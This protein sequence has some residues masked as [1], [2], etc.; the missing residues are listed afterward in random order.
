MDALFDSYEAAESAYRSYARRLGFG[1]R[2]D[3]AIRKD[4]AV[5]KRTFVCHREGKPPCRKE[6]QNQELIQ[7]QPRSRDSSRCGCLAMM[8]ISL[9]RDSLSATFRHW[10]VIAFR[11]VLRNNTNAYLNH[12]RSEH[13]H[14]L[15][16]LD[17]VH[18]LSYYRRFTEEQKIT[19]STLRSAELRVPEIYNVLSK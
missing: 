12:L 6:T 8:R 16:S 10:K 17:E 2:L 15:I 11:L 7:K 19:I 14:E 4:G 18:L 1:V 5:V 9:E 13:N 3:S